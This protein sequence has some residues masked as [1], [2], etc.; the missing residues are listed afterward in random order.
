M[1][2]NNET[3]EADD[4]FNRKSLADKIADLI[5]IS[6][7]EGMR[8]SSFV[9]A[10]NASWGNGKTT[11]VNK[12]INKIKN[13]LED[14]YEKLKAIPIYYNAWEEDDYGNAFESLIYR[15]VEE[16][17]E[18]IETEPTI[19][20]QFEIL[21]R[22]LP[23]IL[24]SVG[25]S[26]AKTKGIDIDNLID[27]INETN[28]SQ[29]T[30]NESDYFSKYIEFKEVKKRFKDNLK[31]LSSEKKIII[32][33]DELDRCRPDFAIE[34]L[35]IVKHYFDIPNIVFV[36]SL[37]IEQLS[38]SIATCYGQ[39]MDSSGYIRR[40]IDFQVNIPQAKLN[41]IQFEI[42][43]SNSVREMFEYFKLSIRDVLKIKKD[44]MF[45]FKK[46]NA[47]EEITLIYINLIIIKYKYP[48]ELERLLNG[49]IEINNEEGEK[50]YRKI[51]FPNNRI[52][53]EELT[54]GGNKILLSQIKQDYNQS[55]KKAFF[56]ISNLKNN[57]HTLGQ[58][59]ER[60]IEYVKI[61]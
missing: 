18:Q 37:D 61:S 12:L 48:N 30:L 49:Y 43:E 1:S 33:I 22:N 14:K 11:F 51:I 13:P 42:A 10:L 31:N 7:E 32:F 46:F 25:K 40:F 29:K 39:N 28:N 15:I 60:V 24:L 58:H 54:K 45:F 38:H 26:Y 6:E 9:I 4:L 27:K 52:Y 47:R 17:S 41:N 21:K 35:E 55:Y 36:L 44:L 56:V 8:E 2:L 3:F 5:S 34:T 57:E 16:I 53:F 23:E 59:I 50:F 20:N 19:K